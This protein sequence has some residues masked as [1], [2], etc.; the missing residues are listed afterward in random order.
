MSY[1]GKMNSSAKETRTLTI[2][3][4]LCRKSKS[5]CGGRLR[6]L[7]SRWKICSRSRRLCNGQM[8]ISSIEYKT[9]TIKHVVV[10]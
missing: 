7:G 3:Q 10:G 5:E 9:G 6:R 1:V 2:A 8:V 4:M